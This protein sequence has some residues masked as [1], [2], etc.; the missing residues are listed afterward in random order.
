MILTFCIDVWLGICMM[1]ISAFLIQFFI[2]FAYSINGYADGREHENSVRNFETIYAYESCIN[3]PNTQIVYV[4]TGQYAYAYHSRS[5]CPGLG[6]C[7][8]EI[9]YTDQYTAENKLGRVPCCRCWSNVAGRCKDDNPY[10]SP[11]TQFNP[12]VPQT[13]SVA[14][15]PDYI[16][17]RNQREQEQAEAIAA[18]AGIII[19]GV[20]SLLA[21]TPEGIARREAKREIR[22]DKRESRKIKKKIR[23]NNKTYEEAYNYIVSQYDPQKSLSN[24]TAI[25]VP[26]SN[27]N[28][29]KY[30]FTTTFKD[31]PF[32]IPLRSAPRVTSREIYRCP[33]DALVY[34][35]ENSNDIYCKVNVNGHVGY[36]TKTFLFRTK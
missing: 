7:K 20:G 9:R 32:E 24:N 25:K 13:P 1:K 5:D 23:P 29:G 34:V 11:P 36:I 3:I 27:E 15:D 8:G 10:Y 26:A 28:K 30:L 2:V 4:C 35:I 22:H 18:L 17:A 19:Q 21:P 31:P 6:N 14:Y 16:A 33:I 12:Y